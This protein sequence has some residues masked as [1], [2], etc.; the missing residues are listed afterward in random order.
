MVFLLF[1]EIYQNTIPNILKARSMSHSN[2]H[3]NAAGLPGSV[4]ANNIIR[5][6]KIE[7]YPVARPPGVR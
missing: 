3:T 6:P 4:M 2:G 7:I 1:F 5:E